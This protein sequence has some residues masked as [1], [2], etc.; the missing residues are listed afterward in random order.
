MKTSNE[1]YTA[2]DEL[3]DIA[4]TSLSADELEMLLEDL[5]I[6]IGSIPDEGGL[7]PSERQ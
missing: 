3:L 6:R 2:I 5:E 4:E 1:I 7:Y